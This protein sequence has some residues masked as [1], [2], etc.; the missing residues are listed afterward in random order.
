ML[1]FFCL[2]LA[3][4]SSVKSA[5]GLDFL[6]AGLFITSINII[7]YAATILHFFRGQSYV[8]ILTRCVDKKNL[9]LCLNYF[10]FMDWENFPFHSWL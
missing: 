1:H 3:N 4:F 6:F 10:L 8:V 5:L 2:L 7:Y 9:I